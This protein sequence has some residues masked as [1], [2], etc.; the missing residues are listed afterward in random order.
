[1]SST[2]L[3]TLA[4]LGRAAFQRGDLA[5]ADALFRRAHAAGRADAEILH[6]LGYIARSRDNLADA[7]NFYA[8]ALARAP[9]DA[10]LHNNLAEVRRAQNR[11]AEALALYRRAVALAPGQAEIHGNLGALLMALHRPDEALP[12]LLTA[13]ALRPELHALRSD[14]AL[15]LSALGRYPETILQYRAAID[16]HPANASARYLEALALLATGDF[17]R[18]WC[19][20]EARWYAELGATRRR[21]FDQPY[22]LGEDNLAGQ[23]I[24][25]H[26]E[27]GFGDTLWLARYVPLVAAMAG[28]VTL[29]VHP[30]LKPLLAT[31]HGASGV[32]ARGE[33][34]P[35]FDQ[36]CSFMSLPRAFRTTLDSIPAAVPYLAPPPERLAAWRARAGSASGRRR[37]AF[38]WSGSQ[39]GPWNR[40]MPLSLLLPLL[41]RPDCDWHVA[42]ADVTDADRR[43]LAG[44]PNVT[45]HSMALHD[46]ADTA[47]LLTA[48]DL[49]I[50]VD[51]ALIHLAGALARPVWTLLPLGADYRWMMQ[52]DDSPWYP[53]MRLFRQPRLHDWAA[54]AASVATALDAEPA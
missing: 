31:L 4:E 44:L 42:Q 33:T 3:D 18:G 12:H 35:R 29:E 37:I 32:F 30:E 39:G 14:A 9:T 45:D 38:T 50:G 2:I 48:M 34:L 53:T 22:W 11:D 23:T 17:E 20:H 15:A 43:L 24:L 26:A 5:E 27:Q 16:A 47:A 13:L 51:T 52:R 41:R 6:F 36:H 7:G 19:R 46:F 40:D 54:V 8:A 25:L 28:Q 1:M 49:V 21:V 10:Q